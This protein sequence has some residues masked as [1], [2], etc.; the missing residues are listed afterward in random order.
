MY[1][2]SMQKCALSSKISR[3]I[4]NFG[5]LLFQIY[6]PVVKVFAV[7]NEIAVV[8]IVFQT[9][10]EPRVLAEIPF[11]GL[12]GRKRVRLSLVVPPRL[13]VL[14]VIRP[15]PRSAVTTNDNGC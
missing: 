9:P 3:S 7:E 13:R 12:V 4:A 8:W 11:S 10:V 1:E 5:I 2:R 14:K 15:V 6:F